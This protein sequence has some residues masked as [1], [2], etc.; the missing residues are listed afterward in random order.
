MGTTAPTSSPADEKSRSLL[1]RLL[2]NR[3]YALLWTAMA[4]SQFG[5]IVFNIAMILWVATTLARNAPW[6]AFAVG[7]LTFLPRIVTFV[8]SSVAGVYVDRWNKRRTL[9]LTDGA[10]TILTFIL[11]LAVSTVPLLFPVG[12]DIAAI[13][14]LIV[15]LLII[16]LMS[17][18]TPFVNGALVAILYEVVEEADFP[19]AFGREQFVNNLSIILAPLSFSPLACNG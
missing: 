17:I 6:V 10:N 5:N 3:N 11:V 15:L 4:T 18:C 9:L 1:Q 8:F 16:G 14:L 13:F 12:S 19:T 2:I 7:A